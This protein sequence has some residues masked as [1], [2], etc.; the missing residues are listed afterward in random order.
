[1]DDE[2]SED[3][4]TSEEDEDHIS[5]F[6]Q[7]PAPPTT[8]KDSHHPSLPPTPTTPSRPCPIPHPRTPRAR[9]ASSE[10]SE[11][12][13]KPTDPVNVHLHT[14]KSPSPAHHPRSKVRLSGEIDGTFPGSPLINGSS[15]EGGVSSTETSTTEGRRLAAALPGAVQLLPNGASGGGVN[16][17]ALSPV[18]R[19]VPKPRKLRQS[20]P[21]SSNSESGTHQIEAV[22]TTPNPNQSENGSK[23][24]KISHHYCEIGMIQDT[25]NNR[26]GQTSDIRT[27]QVEDSSRRDSI[28]ETKTRKVSDIKASFMSTDI[29]TGQVSDI[30]TSQISGIRTSQVSDIRSRWESGN[31]GGNVKSSTETN[32]L[33]KAP[34]SRVTA[35]SITNSGDVDS[36][37]SSMSQNLVNLRFRANS[38]ASESG[39]DETETGLESRA[40]S[41]GSNC[42]SGSPSPSHTKPGAPMV[43][44][45][46]FQSVVQT[47][48]IAEC[49]SPLDQSVQVKPQPLCSRLNLT[50]TLHAT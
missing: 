50:L 23:T 6:S 24:R 18:H 40:W 4:S 3:E 22:D 41:I 32:S 44:T 1:M 33:K 15:S 35:N 20:R 38:N 48:E 10:T 12:N 39:L 11:D 42:S 47:L 13:P 43:C 37:Q 21:S 26:T 29:R 9:K 5:S 49:L 2:I 46:H 19:P 34:A 7:Q 36:N 27:T 31:I 17:N 30:R 16:S 45:A 14:E 25:E 28:S 8:P